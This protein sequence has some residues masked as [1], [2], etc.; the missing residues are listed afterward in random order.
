[1]HQSGFQKFWGF[2]AVGSNKNFPPQK[3]TNHHLIQIRWTPVAVRVIGMLNLEFALRM[4][5]F[6]HPVQKLRVWWFGKK[7]VLVVDGFLESVLVSIYMSIRNDIIW[8]I[9]ISFLSYTCGS[10]N[11]KNESLSTRSIMNSVEHELYMIFNH[12][13]AARIFAREHNQIFVSVETR[14]LAIV[15]Q[16][17][18][19]E[20]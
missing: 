6:I 14:S 15:K 17:K 8:Y 19:P 9:Y 20:D 1:M 10:N 12:C 4:A 18:N 7:L 13:L 2:L 11:D 16:Q 3:Y 5:S